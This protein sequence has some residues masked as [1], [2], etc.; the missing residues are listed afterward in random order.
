MREYK[1][2]KDGKYELSEPKVFDDGEMSRHKAELISRI[3]RM[4]KDIQSLTQS[5]IE[6]EAELVKVEKVYPNPDK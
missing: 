1:K 6:L 2:R 3:A 5:I 4:N